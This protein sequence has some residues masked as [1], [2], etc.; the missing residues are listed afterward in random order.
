MDAFKRETDAALKYAG[1]KAEK[2]KP[3]K[4]K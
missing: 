4:K 1:D 3:A 2:E